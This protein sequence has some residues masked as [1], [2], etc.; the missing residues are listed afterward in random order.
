MHGAATVS[1][2]IV[3]LSVSNSAVN[4][5]TEM[6]G[7]HTAAAAA[8]AADGVQRRRHCQLMAI[9]RSSRKAPS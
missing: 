9:G 7:V 3:G 5:Y 6:D 4:V 8:A 2:C 1:V